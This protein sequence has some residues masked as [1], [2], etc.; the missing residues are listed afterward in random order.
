MPRPYLMYC[1]FC[2]KEV[3]RPRNGSEGSD[4]TPNRAIDHDLPNYTTFS[5]AP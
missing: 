2:G 1:L 5:R 4:R 3:I